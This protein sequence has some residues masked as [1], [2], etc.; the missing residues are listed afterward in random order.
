MPRGPAW[1]EEEMRLLRE[2]MHLPEKVLTDKLGRS[3]SAVQAMKNRVRHNRLPEQRRLE[4]VPGGHE[5]DTRPSGWYEEVVGKMLVEYAPAWEAWLHYH[6]YVEVVQTGFRDSILG[7]VV[8]LQ[9]R[10]DASAGL[11]GQAARVRTP[12]IPPQ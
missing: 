3:K 9:C 12:G 10:R 7:G 6:R 4:R 11:P 1:S 5:F 8:Q 2:N